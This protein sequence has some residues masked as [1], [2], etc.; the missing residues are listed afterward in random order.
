MSVSRLCSAGSSGQQRL[1]HAKFL[2]SELRNRFAQRVLEL[3][4]LPFGIPGRRGICN[5]IKQYSCAAVDLADCPPPDT[6]AKDRRFTG[7][8]ERITAEQAGLPNAMLSE[9]R[10]LNT[11]LTAGLPCRIRLSNILQ[12]FFASRIGLQLL[13]RN[14]IT[15][16]SN[17][18]GFVGVFELECCPSKLIQ[19][20]AR[21]ITG[22]CQKQMG[23]CP[24]VIVQEASS[25]SLVC[26]PS[27]VSY[28]LR[29][30]LKNACMAVVRE[31]NGADVCAA[32]PP[33]ICHVEHSDKS[34]MIKISDQGGG[35][36]AK[37]MRNAWT[38]MHST[39][40]AVDTV[41]G[42]Y[43]VGLPMSR[44]YAQYFGGDLKLQ[45]KEGV[46]TDVI[47]MLSRLDMQE[48]LPEPLPFHSGPFPSA[49]ALR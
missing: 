22:L 5:V 34:V 9:M 29:E 31:H 7:L 2:Q 19:K 13:M 24:Q 20:A 14:Y 3:K 44:V 25:G 38:F 37:A 35:M 1:E 21:Q 39:F 36:S 49:L 12:R 18:T 47:L 42:G 10:S 11:E 33:V 16:W 48:I 32:L 40:G 8:L 45:S 15:S 27:H 17:P 23:Q 30:V 6:L 26:I 41:M 43:G 46:G 4:M 28:I